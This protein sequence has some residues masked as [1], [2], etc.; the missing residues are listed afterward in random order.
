MLR[1]LLIQVLAFGLACALAFLLG[2]PALAGALLAA[3]MAVGF[4]HCLRQRDW[5][6]RVL[7]AL[8]PLAL[9]AGMQLQL[10]G[11][12]W[13]LAFVSCWL[14]YAGAI[15]NRVPLYLS[16]AHALRLLS[17]QIPPQA[18]FVDLG[19]GTGTVLAWLARY[20]PDVIAHGVEFA[21][22]PCLI[23]RLRLWRTAAH[24]QR[25]DLF[26]VSLADYDVVYAY[27][28]PE[29]MAQLWEKARAEMKPG[30]ILISNSFG[31]PGLSPDWIGPVQDWKESELLLWRL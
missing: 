25:G 14:V 12:I 30:A 26:A 4:A 5:W 13:L 16:N 17:A 9:L 19:A 29:P 11:W 6:Q 18:R 20:R 22:L 7:H 8:F 23:G 2:W 15:R 24:L 3:P 1:F 10:P 21:W 31:I 27:L 28:S